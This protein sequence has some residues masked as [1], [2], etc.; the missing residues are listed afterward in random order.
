MTENSSTIIGHLKSYCNAESSFAVAYFYFDFNDI[1]KQNVD[2]CLSSIIAQLCGDVTK[3][4]EELTALYERCSGS[5]KVAKSDLREIFYLFAIHNELK[6]V[7]IVFDAL[8]ECLDNEKRKSRTE[9]LEL[10]MEITNLSQSNMHLLV[11]SRPE[12][13]IKERLTSLVTHSA[14]SIQGS[15]LKSD[16]SL[17]INSELS[18]DPKLRKWPDEMKKEIK[19]ALLIKADGMYANIA[20][21]ILQTLTISLGFAGCSVSLTH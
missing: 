12:Y 18:T 21:I 15:E 14:I 2:N 6:K 19:Q 20:D 3:L 8:D 13:D 16:I 5:A 10:I 1:E 9:L 17:H 7:F 4:P 11:T